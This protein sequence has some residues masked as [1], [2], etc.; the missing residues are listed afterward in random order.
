MLVNPFFEYD[1]LTGLVSTDRHS[2]LLT[3]QLPDDII[4]WESKPKYTVD[5]FK[6]A[7]KDNDLTLTFGGDF[8]GSIESTIAI[9]AGLQEIEV[10]G[11]PVLIALM[12]LAFDGVVAIIFPLLLI[13]WNIIM[14]FVCLRLIA[15]GFSVTT[16]A[17]NVTLIFG[18]G[19][20]IDFTIFMH[21]R[22]TEEMNKH[23][24]SPT[25]KPIDAV[26]TMLSTSGRTVTF[27]AILLCATL[28]GV[29]QFNEYFLT[30]M[31]LAIMLPAALSC[32]G[33]LTF[34]PALYLLM[35]KNV[36]LLSTAPLELFVTKLFHGLL[37]LLSTAVK[38]CFDNSLPL[39][40]SCAKIST[41][42]QSN[43]SAP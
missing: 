4:N 37:A 41:E 31:T 5:D 25:Y 30:T 3:A 38:A 36:F 20:A 34:L 7:T 13:I 19:L 24:H 22:F 33:A 11:A 15:L 14:S 42:N 18:V 8:L 17:T 16:Y 39:G 35:G 40:N 43:L 10:G 21:L 28:S 29:L 27:S 23:A 32:I 1:F 9:N 26:A 2:A 6:A 12:I